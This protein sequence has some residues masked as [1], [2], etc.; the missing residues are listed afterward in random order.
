MRL[1]IHKV[2]FFLGRFGVSL[3]L[4][5]MMIWGGFALWYQFPGAQIG[6]VI[7]ISLWVVLA[8]IAVWHVWGGQTRWPALL[9]Y[10]VAFAGLLAWWSTIKPSND[11]DWADDVA[12][13][14]H[15]EVHGDQVTLD[16]VRNFN[17]RTQTDYDVRWETRQYDLKQLVS[18]DLILSYWMGP[19]IAHTLVSF[20]FKDGSHVVFSLEIRKKRHESFSAIGGFFR[21]F[22][23]VMIAAD[24]RDIVRVRTNVRGEQDYL[25]RL[26]VPEQDLRAMFLNYM[27][28]AKSLEHTP[29]FYN[30]LTTNC[31]TIVYDLAKRVAPSLPLDYRLILSGYLA[32]YAQDSGLL[33]PHYD[34]NTLQQRGYIN[35]RAI[36]AGSDPHFSALIRQGVPGIDPLAQ[37]VTQAIKMPTY[38]VPMT[39]DTSGTAGTNRK[40]GTGGGQ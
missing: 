15:T 29:Q 19:A 2:L 28:E 7:A 3:V 13:V 36:A 11:R 35:P 14:L 37:P 4:V 32:E 17:W 12:Y 8:S 9:L 26:H 34:F 38:Q 30:T 21:E 31:T 18:A 10:G 25:Y 33:T 20:G 24:E 1:P 39:A 23:V 16:R 27:T 5:C 6:K 22:E 40:T